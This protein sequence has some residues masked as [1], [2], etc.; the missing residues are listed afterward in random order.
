MKKMIVLVLVSL[1]VFQNNTSAQKVSKNK[2][3]KTVIIINSD[4][5]RIDGDSAFVFTL[6]GQL[7]NKEFNPEVLFRSDHT[8]R[9]FLGVTMEE[10]K[11]KG[12]KITSVIVKSPAEKAGLQKGDVITKVN[13]FTIGHPQDLTEKIRNMKPGDKVDIEYFRDGKKQ[14]VSVELANS[15]WPEK[16]YNDSAW[17]EIRNHLPELF[18]SVS[19]LKFRP[20]MGIQVQETP[21]DN[22]VKVLSVEENSPAEKAGIKEGDLLTEV[23]GHK[24][25]KI[26][27]IT[28]EIKNNVSVD[29][30]LKVLRDGKILNVKIHI[31]KP[32]RKAN[33]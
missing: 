21:D 6:P 30:D 14:S 17:N 1:L 25:R 5:V 18:G 29:T 10:S 26:T 23:N 22:G 20:R 3:G 15:M 7:F 9:A 11:A 8:D 31:P 33:L 12:A 28:D 27:D 4:S 2:N 13:N 24:I 16:Y 19:N 32:L